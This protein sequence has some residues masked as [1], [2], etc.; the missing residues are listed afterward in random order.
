MSSQWVYIFGERS[1]VDI[2]IGRTQAATAASRLLGVNNEQTTSESYVCLAAVVGSGKD[3]AIL[4]RTFAHLRREKGAKTEY[5]HP[6]PELVEYAAWLRSQWFISPDGRDE[7]EGFAQVES[8]V[9][10]PG[11]GRRIPMPVPDPEKMVQDYEVLGGA[12]EST[13]WAWFPNAKQSIQDY[14]TPPDIME[15]VK[16]GMGGIDLDA[17]SHW[18]ANQKHKIDRYFHI[19]HSAFEHDWEGKVWLN[20]PYGEN[21]EWWPRALKF[22]ESGQVEQLAILSP[23]WAFTTQIA[24]PLMDRST[25]LLLLSPTPK[26]WGNDTR[27]AKTGKLR[28]GSNMP[29]AIVYIGHRPSEVLTALRPFGIPCQ[30]V[31]DLPALQLVEAA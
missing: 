12:L 15:A 28:T 1:G 22:V 3:E 27:S 26:F 16:R 23:V 21:D 30:L 19:G 18:L 4:K 10:L 13:A 25:A 6:E 31:L 5:F 14:F 9:W 20:P 11:H 24:R 17:A 8:D 7:R 2:K 29:H